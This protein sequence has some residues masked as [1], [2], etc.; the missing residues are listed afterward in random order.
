MVIFS[1]LTHEPKEK[2]YYFFLFCY[3]YVF[4]ISHTRFKC[5]LFKRNKDYY[6]SDFLDVKTYFC[7]THRVNIERESFRNNICI[8]EAKSVDRKSRDFLQIS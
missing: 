8:Q 2:D 4:F 1:Q 6:A 7:S 3:N 5:V